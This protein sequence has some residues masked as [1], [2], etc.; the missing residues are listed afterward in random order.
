[1]KNRKL[2]I[3]LTSV[4]ALMF[5]ALA[6][7]SKA[8]PAS[9]VAAANGARPNSPSFVFPSE[10]KAQVTGRQSPYSA[11]TRVT[12]NEEK[13]S[14]EIPVEWNDI[15]TG[16]WTYKGRNVGV[17]VAASGN[18]ANFYSTHS[19]PG[20]F[21]GVSHAL[22]NAYGKDGL[23][24]LE[25]RDHSQCHYNGR[26]DYQNLF[27]KGQYDHYAN[28]TDGAPNLLVFTTASADGKY[29]I[30]LRIVVVSNADVEAATTIFNTFQVLGNPERD[31]HHGP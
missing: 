6:L 23:L 11:Y 18:L 13:I 8:S 30:L 26:F 19:Q 10:L 7:N 27:Y 28:C 15:E 22:A 25:K 2:Y 1:M 3:R 17:F 5:I 4:L 12:D 31:D 21:I 24:G 14:M 20:V 29:L 9:I 16:A